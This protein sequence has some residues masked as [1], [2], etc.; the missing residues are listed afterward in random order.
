MQPQLLVAVE[1][2]FGENDLDI[3]AVREGFR[4]CPFTWSM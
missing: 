3:E 4:Q 1:V 2:F